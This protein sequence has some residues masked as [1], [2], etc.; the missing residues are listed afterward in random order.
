MTFRLYCVLIP[1]KFKPEPIT[2]RRASS[3]RVPADGLHKLLD[4]TS[5]S[6]PRSVSFSFTCRST[7]THSTILTSN[8]FHPNTKGETV[9]AHASTTFSFTGAFRPS[10]SRCSL[11]RTLRPS[12]FCAQRL[13][14][15]RGNGRPNSRKSRWRRARSHNPSAIAMGHT[16]G[17]STATIISERAKVSLLYLPSPGSKVTCDKPVLDKHAHAPFVFGNDTRPYNK[18][19]TA[20]AAKKKLRKRIRTEENLHSGTANAVNCKKRVLFGEFLRQRKLC[21]SWTYA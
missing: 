19:S 18:P 13:L 1:W 4:R 7:V 10:S 6:I 2:R 5:V 9:V 3:K 16:H 17:V 15:R 8:T 14:E 20:D 21:H 11:R 12:H